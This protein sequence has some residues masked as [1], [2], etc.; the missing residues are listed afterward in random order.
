MPQ[1]KK[2]TLFQ[3]SDGVQHT[4]ST[5]AKTQQ[6]RLNLAEVFGSEE[7]E[8]TIGKI[9]PNQLFRFLEQHRIAVQDFFDPQSMAADL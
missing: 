7:W 8:D 2:L 6:A 3:T 5:A 1:V 4:S 9:D